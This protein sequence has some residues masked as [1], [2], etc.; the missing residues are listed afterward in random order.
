LAGMTPGYGCAVIRVQKFNTNLLINVTAQ[1]C[2][3]TKK[4][5]LR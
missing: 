1:L 5:N 2:Q 3:F 4:F